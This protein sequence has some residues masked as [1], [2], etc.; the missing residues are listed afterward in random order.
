MIQVQSRGPHQIMAYAPPFNVPLS[1][2]T[3]PRAWGQH[4]GHL[5][6][7]ELYGNAS[8]VIGQGSEQVFSHLRYA[9]TVSSN[10]DPS[11]A[12]ASPERHV[13]DRHAIPVRLVDASSC[14]R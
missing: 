14:P 8:T 9:Q 7:L 3:R 1:A 13:R 10:G 2:A 4:H 6:L 5:E 12:G 11:T